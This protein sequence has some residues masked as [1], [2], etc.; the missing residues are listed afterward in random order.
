MS[1]IPG[2]EPP[3]PPLFTFKNEDSPKPEN[4][5]DAD[6]K[7]PKPGLYYRSLSQAEVTL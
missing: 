6:I 5:Q 7:T 4:R 1:T 2:L 3:E